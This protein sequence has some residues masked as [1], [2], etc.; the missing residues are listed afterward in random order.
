M[1][2]GASESPIVQ[3]LNRLLEDLG[4]TPVELCHSLGYRNGRHAKQGPRRLDLWLDTGNGYGRILDQIAAAKRQLGLECRR[5]GVTSCFLKAVSA[6]AR[7][8][9]LRFDGHP[10]RAVHDD[11]ARR[12]LR[13]PSHIDITDGSGARRGLWKWPR[14]SRWR[15]GEPPEPGAET[16]AITFPQERGGAWREIARRAW[17]LCLRTESPMRCSTPN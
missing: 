13:K 12:R 7:A 14:A 17:T 3:F 4:F 9:E 1:S 6:G 2:Q 16:P 15:F 5:P 11:F 8:P 10:L